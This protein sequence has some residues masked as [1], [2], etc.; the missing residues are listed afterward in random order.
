M[1]FSTIEFLFQFLPIFLLAYY[2]TPQKYRN[3]TLI[4]GSLV[5]YAIGSG[6]Y[7]LLLLLSLV[8]NYG[9]SRLISGSHARHPQQAKRYLIGGLVYNF[10]LLVVFKYTNFLIG[11]L[12]SLLSIF[13]VAIPKASII[14]PLGISFF[15]F[16]ITSY[17]IDVYQ[18]K[19]RPA[20]SL[21]DLGVYLCMFPQLISGPIC[22]YSDTAETLAKGE[23]I[24]SENLIRGY[25]RIG[26]GLLKKV[27]IADRL[28]V[29][30][31]TLFDGY[32][33]Y[34]GVMIVVAA[35]SYTVQLYMEFSGCMDIVIG[36]AEC[37]GVTLPEN[38]A[39]P[40]VSKNASE[41]W[42]RWHIS[43]GRWFKTYIFYP[44]SMSKLTRKW[45][46]FAK[47]HTSKYIKLMVAS[48]IALFPVWVCNGL[49]HG[50][51]WSY[52]FYGMYY[53][54][55]IMIELMLEPAVKKLCAAWKIAEDAAW[56]NV[57]RILKTWVIIFTG[58]LFFRADTLGIGMHM[59]R[60]LFHD[61][62]IQKLWDGTLLTL[63]L[64]RVEIGIILVSLLIVGVVNHFREQ[65]IDVRGVIL[66]KRLPVRWLVYLA[67]I[68]VVLIFGA[69]G[70]GYQ[71]VDLIYAGF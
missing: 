36:S 6:W 65:Q 31:Q 66:Q 4:I 49:W 45:N 38:F 13:H 34:H 41:F 14:M 46:R 19:T 56:W 8:I 12:N 24:R 23:D 21:L 44:V 54:V 64:G 43:L 47:K 42:R 26:W 29:V 5:F 70:P 25:M 52:L 32:A 39:Q 18:N 37:F 59:F 69:Y 27:V 63:G 35:V 17:L 67:L 60:S 53:F 61:F 22:M 9:L 68:F 16:Q 33:S 10:G 30:V 62:S 20:R 50:A 7:T 3:I 58:E 11:N 55:V 28:Y 2:A 15:T 51:N 1:V 57:L 40:F 71:E 48:A